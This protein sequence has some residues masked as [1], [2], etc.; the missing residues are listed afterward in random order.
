MWS[1]L[2]SL[3]NDSGFIG[4]PTQWAS[5]HTH[6]TLAPQSPHP[7]VCP[8]IL[9]IHALGLHALC[10]VIITF[11]H[12][13]SV[14]VIF[15]VSCFGP[16]LIFADQNYKI[17][18]LSKVKNP[19]PPHFLAGKKTSQFS[20]FQQSSIPYLLLVWWIT[21]GK[22]LLCLGQYYVSNKDNHYH[23]LFI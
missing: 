1:K 20:H 15:G 5:S 9:P 4:H 14:K 18:K 8:D 21:C 7:I 3:C 2:C 23:N 19:P 17:P 22:Q 16:H 6:P 11:N 13:Q 12:Q 10:L